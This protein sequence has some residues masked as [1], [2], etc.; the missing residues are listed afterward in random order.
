MKLDNKHLFVSHI[1]LVKKEN[2]KKIVELHENNDKYFNI[3]FSLS[4]NK[5]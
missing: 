5:I 2:A 1:F 4:K 3:D